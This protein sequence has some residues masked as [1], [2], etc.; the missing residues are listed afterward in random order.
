MAHQPRHPHH[1]DMEH[2]VYQGQHYVVDGVGGKNTFNGS[3]PP[4]PYSGV[5]GSPNCPATT[6]WRDWSPQHLGAVKLSIT[7]GTMTV[8]FWG[9]VSGTPTLLHSFTLTK[10]GTITGKVTDSLTGKIG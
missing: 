10:P 3:N 1:Q 6:V 9:L 4:C 2:L 8:Q 7:P 5:S